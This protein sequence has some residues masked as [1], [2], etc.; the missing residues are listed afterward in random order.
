MGP[1]ITGRHTRMFDLG[2]GVLIPLSSD[3]LGAR[4]IPGLHV[5]MTTV[6]EVE[7][8]ADWE[9]ELLE[10]NPWKPAPSPVLSL[11]QR[12]VNSV[13]DV[14]ANTNWYTASDREIIDAYADIRDILSDYQLE[15]TGL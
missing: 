6:A 14:L 3:N 9:R 11:E 7:P 8:L 4:R 13:Q 15:R 5:A 1:L 12:V 2:R 10:G